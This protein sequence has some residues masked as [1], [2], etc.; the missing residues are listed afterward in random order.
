MEVGQTEEKGGE[1]EPG[2]S[3]RI[4]KDWVRNSP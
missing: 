1:K 2:H 3:L 4:A